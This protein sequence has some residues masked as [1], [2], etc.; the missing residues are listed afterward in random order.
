[1][2]AR[3]EQMDKLRKG[4]D[5]GPQDVNDWYD[6]RPAPPRMTPGKKKPPEWNRVREGHYEKAAGSSTDLPP[7]AM[8]GPK[9]MHYGNQKVKAVR[10]HYDNK[11]V[12]TPA[13]T[14]KTRGKTF[15]F[16]TVKP[17]YADKHKPGAEP[18]K[19][20]SKPKKKISVRAKFQK[21]RKPATIKQARSALS[22]MAGDQHAVAVY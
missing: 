13:K 14:M 21:Q 2:K 4:N 6:N 10:P 9:V 20:E 16:E 8:P 19:E 3:E 11:V 18:E 12:K 17:V 15:K 7:G 5:I 1:M 22:R